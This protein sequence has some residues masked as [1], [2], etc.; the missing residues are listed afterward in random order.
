[1]LNYNESLPVK[2]ARH[3]RFQYR[4]PTDPAAAL[5]RGK[6]TRT[7]LVPLNRKIKNGKKGGYHE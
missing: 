5:N 7:F 3:H 1:M 2:V 6:R 4:K